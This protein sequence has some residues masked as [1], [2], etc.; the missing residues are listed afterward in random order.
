MGV[1]RGWRRKM[2]G[3]KRRKSFQE[4]GGGRTEND[5]W[6]GA[7]SSP[8][9]SVAWDLKTSGKSVHEK[10]WC[11]VSQ[12]SVM[13]LPVLDLEA[14]GVGSLES[15]TELSMAGLQ[16]YMRELP[17]AEQCGAVWF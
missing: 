5:G 9:G 7:V 4:D 8:L 15:Q 11:G 14:P 13:L 6:S 10:D 17:W 1:G 3:P 2:A 12:G 16:V